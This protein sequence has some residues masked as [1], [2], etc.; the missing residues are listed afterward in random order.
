[1]KVVRNTPSSDGAC[2]YE[3]Y[4][5]MARRS[6]KLTDT[7]TDARTDNPRHTKIR[8]VDDGHIKTV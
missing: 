5:V 2:V 8:P 7:R 6:K 1:M 4:E 3:V